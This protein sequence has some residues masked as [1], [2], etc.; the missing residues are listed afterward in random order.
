V[1]KSMQQAVLGDIHAAGAL[2][3][4]DATPQVLGTVSAAPDAGRA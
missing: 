2:L 3:L 1:L 4:Q